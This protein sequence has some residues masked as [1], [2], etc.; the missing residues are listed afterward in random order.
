M[1]ILRLLKAV[2]MHIYKI[3]MQFMSALYPSDVHINIRVRTH[4][5]TTLEALSKDTYEAINP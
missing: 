4:T 5:Q 3:H 1:F 2:E